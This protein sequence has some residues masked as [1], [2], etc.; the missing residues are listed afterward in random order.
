VRQ[1]EDLPLFTSRGCRVATLAVLPDL[2]GGWGGGLEP[3]ATTGGIGRSF[4]FINLVPWPQMIKSL[5]IY[6]L[7]IRQ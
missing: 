5:A 4:L 3:I 6:M 1:V 7:V 2:V